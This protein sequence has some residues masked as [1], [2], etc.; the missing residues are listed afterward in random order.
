MLLGE[1]LSRLGLLSGGPPLSL[2]DMFLV[3]WRGFENL[4]FPL[5]FTLLCGLFVFLDVG[6]SIYPTLTHVGILNVNNLN[7]FETLFHLCFFPG[8]SSSFPF[9]D[10]WSW[11]QCS[12]KPILWSLQ[13][14]TIPSCL[15]YTF[16]FMKILW[17][18][19]TQL[20]WHYCI[21]ASFQNIPKI[22][23]IKNLHRWT[24]PYQLSKY[25]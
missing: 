21:C 17:K 13:S 14:S 5:W 9:V 12:W 19:D 3:A 22:S 23:G 15:M 16:F 4:M 24:E 25:T 8:S 7:Q 6:S 18:F 10:L 1:G 11:A 20:R 2:F